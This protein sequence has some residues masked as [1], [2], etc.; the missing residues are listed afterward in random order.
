MNTSV[1]VEGL[2]ECIEDC[3]ASFIFRFANKPFPNAD[4]LKGVCGTDALYIH[5]RRWESFFAIPRYIVLR[6]QLRK[7]DFGD[8]YAYEAARAS[9]YPVAEPGKR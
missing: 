3:S 2:V 5:P 6:D 8:T 4:L 9:V 7:D 1:L